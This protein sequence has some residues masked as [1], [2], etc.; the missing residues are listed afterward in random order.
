[1]AFPS[2][3]SPGL[4]PPLFTLAQRRLLNANQFSFTLGETGGRLDL[5][6]VPSDP[7]LDPATTWIKLIKPQFWA[8]RVNGIEVELKRPDIG[9]AAPSAAFIPQR[10]R[11]PRSAGT[12]GLLR[13]QLISAE[14]VLQRARVNVRGIG[15]FDSGTTTILCPPA[16]ATYINRL[17]G[18]SDDGLHVDCSASS[19]GP[20]FHFAIGGKNGKD[21]FTIPIASHQ[22]I[23]GDG[24]PEHG[25]MSAFQPGGPKDKWILGLPFFANRTVTFD[26]DQGRIGFSQP[27]SEMA[28][29]EK[30][31]KGT[32]DSPIDDIGD[33]KTRDKK[34][35]SDLDYGTAQKGDADPKAGNIFEPPAD[36]DDSLYMAGRGASSLRSPKAAVV[37]V[38]AVFASI[39]NM[40]GS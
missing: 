31:D 13:R 39:L 36:L 5:G 29:Y 25:C 28:L 20:T 27:Y 33:T 19:S 35:G 23:L 30:I 9:Q 34:D 3:S 15:L 24:S 32:I 38:V 11:A 2:L 4:E 10:V 7:D 37:C 12:Q 26:I 8:V 22:Y 6:Q 1:M 40:L 17:I 16:I 21:S 14:K 18:A